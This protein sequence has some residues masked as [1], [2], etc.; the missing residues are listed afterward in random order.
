MIHNHPAYKYAT[1]VVEGA[2]EAPIYVKKQC[3][4]FIRICDGESPGWKIDEAKVKQIDG[5]TKLMVMPPGGL[6]SGQTV[7][8]A[9][10]GY[11]WLLW[12]GVLCPVSVENPELRRYQIAILEIARKNAKTFDVA[13]FFI[14]LQLTEPKF[15][16]FYSVAPDGKLSRE[17]KDAMTRIIKSS[18]ALI[19]RFKVMRDNII[20]K[21]TD[22]EYVPL[23]YSNDRLDGK[24]PN[25]FLVDEVGALPNN[26]ALEAMRSGQLTIRNKLGC[27]ISTK[28]ARI[29]NPFEDEVQY[30][31]EVLDGL[32]DDPS[33]FALL[34][35]PDNP[36][37]WMTDD[38]V[39]AHANPL[40]LEVPEIWDDLLRRR[41]RAISVPSARE[42]FLCKHCNIIYQG[43]ETESYVSVDDLR[44]G[45]VDHI[46][47]SGREVFLGL[48]L[49]MT[50]DN[51]SVAMVADDGDGGILWHGMVFAPADR[52]DEKSHAERL[53]YW[54]MID[55]GWCIACGDVIVSYAEIEQY[56]LDSEEKFSVRVIGL[57]FDRYNAISSAQKF[58]DGGIQ[59]TIVDQHSRVLH[60]PTKWLSEV[61][62]QGKFHYEDNLLLEINFQNAR[63]TY[64]TNLNR[65]V[66]KKKSSGKIDMVAATINAVYLLQQYIL[67][68]GGWVAIY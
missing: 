17:I 10:A 33:L 31:K 6:K 7:Y 25:G 64:D 59:C 63:C 66:S 5:L 60:A 40:A 15:S 8:E 38:R 44:K 26:Y 50:N 12:V 19:D 55:E 47:W 22:S 16:K 29:D 34:Y 35:E 1:R 49:A 11:Q 20:C 65:Y 46:D 48:D 18:P 23:N 13:V 58:E 3:A 53:D 62:E 4:E 54:R 68:G 28:Y 27:I 61:I 57:G 52:I 21:L 41:S 9:A 39:L 2:V 32:K 37:D 51:C 43:V 36:K 42:N 45:K 56:V 67:S 24:L 14:L 30:A